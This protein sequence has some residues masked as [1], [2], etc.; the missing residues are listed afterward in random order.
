[1][2]LL[3]LPC[4]HAV[5]IHDTHLLNTLLP[6]ALDDS[7]P[8]LDILVHHAPRISNMHHPCPFP[9]TRTRRSSTF[10]Q[11]PG[12]PHLLLPLLPLFLLSLLLALLALHSPLRQLLPQP[13]RALPVLL[14]LCLCPF[15]GGR[16]VLGLFFLGSSG[17]LVKLAILERNLARDGGFGLPVLYVAVV[18]R[19]PLV[20]AWYGGGLGLG[21]G[22]DGAGGLGGADFFG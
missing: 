14:L 1:M 22:G 9:L 6:L 5:E 17:V 4:K 2:E 12:L 10:D 19:L 21:L 3:W 11:L 7:L 18:G 20:H 8:S 15:L 16:L 13:L